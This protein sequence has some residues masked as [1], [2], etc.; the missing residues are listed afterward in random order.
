MSAASR[1]EDLG[2]LSL[3]AKSLHFRS[4]F[5][6]P[7]DLPIEELRLLGEYT[8]EDGPHVADHFLVF[9]GPGGRAFE[10]PVDADG[11]VSVLRELGSMF[12]VPMQLELRFNTSFASR[13]IWPPQLSGQ[14]LFTVRAKA[15]RLADRIKSAIGFGRVELSLRPAIARHV[16]G[17]ED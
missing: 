8:N 6:Q 13:A 3:T 4:S 16:G 1:S 5:Y 11:T 2:Q 9:F 12:S 17:H 15:E 10:A 7:W 14:E